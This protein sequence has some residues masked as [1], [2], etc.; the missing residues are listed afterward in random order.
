MPETDEYMQFIERWE[1]RRDVTYTDTEGY[2]TVGVGFNLGRA[3]AQERLEQVGADYERVLTGQD[4]LTDSQ[5]DALLRY[6]VDS[7]MS[8]ARS[9]VQNFDNLPEDGQLIVV[10]M[11][12]N[13][14]ADGFA[15]FENTIDALNDGDWSRAATEM[16]DSLWFDQVG[17][18][19]MHHVESM[20]SLAASNTT[21]VDDY[22]VD[23]VDIGTSVPP[24]V[25]PT[26]IDTLKGTDFW[27]GLST[28]IPEDSPSIHI[29]TSPSPT[30]SDFSFSEP[31][32]PDTPAPDTPAPDLLPTPEPVVP[33]P[34]PPPDPTV[35]P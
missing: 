8:Q 31:V 29:D 21:D 4:Q 27:E 23:I 19:G 28:G 18:R 11:V 15:K 25:N 3:D 5:I 1:G 20:S 6:D 35:I 14:G 33:D 9:L 26:D 2:P 34:P 30:T 24:P 12:Y 13:L 10:D 17:D 22:W 32:M 16:Q 7:A